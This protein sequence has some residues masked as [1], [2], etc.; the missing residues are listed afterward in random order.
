MK[1]VVAGV[2]AFLICAGIAWDIGELM[3]VA[4]II[5]VML[6]PSWDPAVRFKEWTMG[7]KS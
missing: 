4:I 7:R 6:P 3:L 2:I 1:N 5:L